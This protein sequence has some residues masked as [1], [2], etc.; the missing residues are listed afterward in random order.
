MAKCLLTSSSY[1]SRRL[2]YMLMLS[3]VGHSSEFSA[4]ADATS[5]SSLSLR[6]C[7]V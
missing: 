2:P 6:Q 3:V 5:A 4:D 7:Y 1:Y